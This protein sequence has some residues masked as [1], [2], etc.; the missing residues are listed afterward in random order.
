MTKKEYMQPAT[1]VMNIDLHVQILAGSVETSGLDND[2]LIGDDTP[3]DSWN[4]AM[5]RRHRHNV[6]DDEELMEEEEDW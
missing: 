4:E 3:G 6:W 2:E 1:E 5:S